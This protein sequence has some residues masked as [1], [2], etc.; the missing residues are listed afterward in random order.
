MAKAFVYMMCLVGIA[1]ALLRRYARAVPAGPAV[2][3]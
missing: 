1:A 2:R 3:R